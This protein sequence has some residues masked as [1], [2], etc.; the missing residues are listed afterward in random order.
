MAGRSE[1]SIKFNK[2]IE[3]IL[4]N[5]PDFAIEWA[6]NME[7]GGKTGQTRVVFVR[8][9]RRYL[10]SVDRDMKSIEPD[11]L[12]VRKTQEYL[13]S[14]KKTSSSDSYQQQVWCCLNNFFK[15]L[16][17]SGYKEGNPMEIIDKTKNHDLDRINHNRLLLTENDFNKILGE[18]KKEK[19]YKFQNR[20]MAVI[21]IFM[22]TG[23]RKTAL[24]EIDID[25]ID[26]ENRVLKV[27]DKGNKYQVYP[28]DDE[29]LG[30]I[31]LWMTERIQYK[32][33]KTNA[34]FV[35]RIGTRITGTTIDNIVAK[36]SLGALGKKISPHKLRAGFVSI[37]YNKTKD[38]EATR[39]AV[40]HSNIATTQRYIVT[41]NKERQD[42]VS[43]MSSFLKF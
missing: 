16:V 26:F 25:D 33:D 5:F 6:R 14:I 31:R 29:V 21:L 34:L 19:D 10:R 15:Y 27:I 17:M 9:I 11:Q 12:N 4:Q 42:A 40:G 8:I 22:Y 37:Y 7:A 32:L 35:S 36:Y 1:N 23:I 20:D 13:I 38:I 18:I 2:N 28:L 41:D 39:R 24:S 43:Y 3:D 30:V